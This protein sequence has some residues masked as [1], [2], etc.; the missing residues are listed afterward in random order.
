[1]T[2]K[3]EM[4]LLVQG[5]QHSTLAS[6]HIKRDMFFAAESKDTHVSY[7]RYDDSGSLIPFRFLRHRDSLPKP[8]PTMLRSWVLMPYWYPTW[9]RDAA[10][11]HQ[12]M[13]N[14][15][16]TAL[17]FHV[18]Q[19]AQYMK[20]LPKSSPWSRIRILS[21]AV[22]NITSLIAQTLRHQ[23]LWTQRN[24]RPSW[25]PNT[26]AKKPT[27]DR[28]PHVLEVQQIHRQYQKPAL[29]RTHN[30]PLSIV[31]LHAQ[32]HCS[33]RLFLP[34]G[35]LHAEARQSTPALTFLSA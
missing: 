9:Q 22:K 18:S 21:R 11:S 2:K 15:S 35:I 13:L 20:Y 29:T 23:H 3:H 4:P 33:S 1:M 34:R 28:P 6:P 17:R 14:F 10:V 32:I 5:Y 12:L 16:A 25:Y 19:V 8:G 26:K 7:G 24:D 30:T 31:V 27:S